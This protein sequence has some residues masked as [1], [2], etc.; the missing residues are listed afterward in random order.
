M[1][2][3]EPGNVRRKGAVGETRVTGRRLRGMAREAATRG[4]AGTAEMA[5]KVLHPG[6]EV[7]GDERVPTGVR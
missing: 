3:T 4:G 6:Q 2:V 1:P 7:C 5:G